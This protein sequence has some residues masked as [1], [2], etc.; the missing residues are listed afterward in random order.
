MPSDAPTAVSLL[1]VELCGGGVK[2][3][4]CHFL[5]V[6]LVCLA[7]VFSADEAQAQVPGIT[8]TAAD[9]VVVPENG[10]IVA[11]TV[12]LNSRPMG[13]VEIAIKMPRGNVS[14][15]GL[16]RVEERIPELLYFITFTP[17]NWDQPV[18]VT[19]VD[20]KIDNPSDKR[21][22]IL[23][24]S[25][26]NNPNNVNGYE[27]LGS[28]VLDTVNVE[29]VDNDKEPHGIV[30]W[31][32]PSSVN[33][34][35]GSILVTV[36]A[37]VIGDT[38]YGVDKIVRVRVAGYTAT[39]GIDF[40]AVPEFQ[41]QLPA[42]A[43]RATGTFNLEL[44]DDFDN[45][46][47]ETIRVFDYLDGV[48]P[49]VTQITIVDND[50]PGV[51]VKVDDPLVLIEGETKTYTIELKTQPT[52]DVTVTQISRNRTIVT[53]LPRQLIFND[54]NWATPQD[55][56][57]TSVQNSNQGRHR[58]TII[59]HVFKGGG[60]DRVQAE[61]NVQVNDDDTAGVTVTAADPVV[62]SENG[63]TATYTVKLNRRPTGPVY[64][65]VYMNLIG[66][67]RL[68]SPHIIAEDDNSAFLLFP[69]DNW[70]QT[71]TVT[72]TG[73]DDK[74][75]NPGDKREIILKHFNLNNPSNVNGYEV[76]GSSVLDTVTIKVID[77]DD[78]PPPETVVVADDPVVVTEATGP[79]NTNT[80]TIALKTRP[81]GDVTITPTSGD[82][83][84]AMV[85]GSLTF[86]ADNWMT[87]QDVTVIGVD[88]RIDNQ[89]NRRATISHT[90]KGGGY[91]A[92]SVDNVTVEV[93]DND[94]ARV[95]VDAGDPVVVTEAA[96]SGRT[97]TYS[98]V[99]HSEPTGNVTITPRIDPPSIATVSGSLTFTADNWMTEQ[100]VTVTGV[101]DDDDN[102]GDNRRATITHDIVG[103]G[104]QAVL[105]DNVTVQLT[106][107]DT[108]G[109]AVSRSVLTVAE[110]GG[111]STYKIKLKTKPT[112]NVTITLTSNDL[113]VAKVSIGSLTFTPDN[114][115]KGQRVTVT[116]ID[117][118]IDNPR[119]R[120]QQSPILPRAAAMMRW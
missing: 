19:G 27:V 101:N 49:S 16:P 14:L 29:V 52:G 113:N 116:G 47:N 11:Y 9:P 63:G 86:T 103:G 7:I 98:L 62:V 84:I 69:L 73:I 10:G 87:A 95:T 3:V 12:K 8:I 34:G 114:W 100:D 59:A 115:N 43:N 4:S 55:V 111:T 61:I 13:N 46:G 28:S 92:V 37:V 99:L 44:L 20:D 57:V 54:T 109:V 76:L 70:N 51:T 96:G 18:T 42:G 85:S 53:V 67:V 68:S 107:D 23:K 94:T 71:A 79:S 24:H 106:D 50:V 104:Y 118:K 88:N 39:E 105:V 66:G 80:Y 6:L 58:K 45:E 41:I 35:A 93:T 1:K 81:T 22:I 77:D 17:D 64:I 90:I 83:D 74:I 119:N 97:K 25:N 5:T 38:T 30:L 120:R 31:G 75:D 91:Q 78:P 89:G 2:D 108:C 60:Y 102:P 21:E 112:A 117:D 15:S 56:T 65:S 82:P 48:V 26:F 110:N 33:E 36:T 32:I 40:K 72:V